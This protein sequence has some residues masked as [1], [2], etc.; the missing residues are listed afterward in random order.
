MQQ[1]GGQVAERFGA[2]GV[3]VDF[4]RAK[5][6]VIEVANKESRV[7]DIISVVLSSSQM[8]LLRGVGCLELGMG[9]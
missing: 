1:N 2:L 5:A 4:K 8:V 7:K 6:G 9:A 3:E